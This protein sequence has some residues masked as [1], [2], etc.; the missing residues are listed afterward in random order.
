MI[1]LEPFTPAT[2]TGPM[3]TS[4]VTVADRSTSTEEQRD[5]AVEHMRQVA[6]AQRADAAA[7][8]VNWSRG[9]PTILEVTFSIEH[10]EGRRLWIADQVREFMLDG[11]EIPHDEAGRYRRLRAEV[12]EMHDRGML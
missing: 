11:G 2:T 3:R 8:R 1:E 12:Q 4:E 7:M 6:T 9:E 10:V 5:Q